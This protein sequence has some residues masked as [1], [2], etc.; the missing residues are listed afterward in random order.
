MTE[1]DRGSVHSMLCP[2]CRVFLP[3]FLRCRNKTQTGISFPDLVQRQLSLTHPL[4]L[5]LAKLTDLWH[6][7]ILCLVIL[8]HGAVGYKYPKNI[9]NYHTDPQEENWKLAR[10]WGQSLRRTCGGVNTRKV[11]GFSQEPIVR[12]TK[13]LSRHNTCLFSHENSPSAGAHN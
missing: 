8:N 10:R 3:N 2:R 1:T 12:N 9:T 11:L 13:H 5:L 6:L 7:D 4:A